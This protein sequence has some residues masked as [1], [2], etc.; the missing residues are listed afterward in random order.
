MRV[1][2][3]IPGPTALRFDQNDLSVA[4]QTYQDILNEQAKLGWI[5]D[6]VHEMDAYQEQITKRGCF[7]PKEIQAAKKITM[8]L[9]I[10]YS[11]VEEKK[12]GLSSKAEPQA[13]PQAQPAID[14]AKA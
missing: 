6:S 12:T 9:L 8:S 1:Y 13:E 5:F 14:D 11:E 7:G 10:F 2:K 3:V 4:S